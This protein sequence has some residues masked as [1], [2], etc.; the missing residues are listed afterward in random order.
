M[1]PCHDAENV[2]SSKALL[3]FQTATFYV[4]L[5]PTPS[6]ITVPLVSK[7]ARHREPSSLRIEHGRSGTDT[8]QTPYSTSSST[9]CWLLYFPTPFL[10]ALHSLR[11]PVAHKCTA[12][13]TQGFACRFI[14]FFLC[15][16]GLL[17]PCQCFSVLPL[18]LSPLCFRYLGSSCCERQGSHH[19][20]IVPTAAVP[21]SHLSSYLCGF[22]PQSRSS[23]NEVQCQLNVPWQWRSGLEDWASLLFLAWFID[24]Q[25]GKCTLSSST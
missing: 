15:L 10:S 3:I 14:L 17:F 13:S 4:S 24:T 9:A 25:M 20:R 23:L 18:L 1:E 16:P 5:K 6:K 19:G 7:L 11:A 2:G 8:C 21:H 12:T 22:G